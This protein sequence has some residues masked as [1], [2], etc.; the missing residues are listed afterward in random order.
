MHNKTENCS[1]NRAQQ[2]GMDFSPECF[3]VLLRCVMHLTKS[4]ITLEIKSIKHK[5]EAR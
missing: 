1:S 3:I 4:Q 5:K 2:H